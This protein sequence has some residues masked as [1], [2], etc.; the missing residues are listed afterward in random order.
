[1]YIHT[2]RLLTHMLC[3]GKRSTNGDNVIPFFRLEIQP[4]A[5]VATPPVARLRALNEPGTKR[6]HFMGT[7]WGCIM[8][9]VGGS[10]SSEKY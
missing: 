10:N 3:L 9:V 6:P 2:L 1:M 5:P 4:P 7:S 8:I